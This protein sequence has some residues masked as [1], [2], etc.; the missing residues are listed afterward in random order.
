LHCNGCLL[1]CRSV[2][3]KNINLG[4]TPT[5][6]EKTWCTMVPF[7]GFGPNIANYKM[8][9]FAQM[10]QVAYNFGIITKFNITYLMLKKYISNL[11][12]LTF[13]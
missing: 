11:C 6:S 7:P 1:G 2:L 13:S 4:L 5:P 12:I 10:E 3:L 8:W 9:P